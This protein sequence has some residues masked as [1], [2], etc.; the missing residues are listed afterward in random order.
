MANQWDRLQG[1]VVVTIIGLATAFIAA[2]VVSFE[3]W[4]FDIKSGY[5]STGW[6]KAHR[7]CTCPVQ[8]APIISVK[9]FSATKPVLRSAVS[10]TAFM[11]AWARKVDNDKTCSAWRQWGQTLGDDNSKAVQWILEYGIYIILAVS[12]L[13]YFKEPRLLLIVYAC[14]SHSQL[15]PPSLQSICLPAPA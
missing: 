5:C 9:T 4:L 7:F 1:W 10:S 3:M 14:R 8:D 12:F 11:N 2:G 6:W 15:L 13:A